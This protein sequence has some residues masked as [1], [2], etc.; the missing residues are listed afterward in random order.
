[1][2]I[3]Q[4]AEFR[5]NNISYLLIHR[6]GD[7]KISFSGPLQNVIWDKVFK[8]GPSKICGRQPLKNLKRHGLL[9]QTKSLQIF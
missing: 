4:S 7:K 9:K 3:R 6:L 2:Y 5:R 8:N 1:M